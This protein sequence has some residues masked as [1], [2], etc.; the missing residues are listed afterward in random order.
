MPDTNR[1]APA[2]FALGSGS[3]GQDSHLEAAASSPLDLACADCRA[4]CRDLIDEFAKGLLDALACVVRRA[5][6]ETL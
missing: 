5:A 2:A 1:L 4:F 3:P 6:T